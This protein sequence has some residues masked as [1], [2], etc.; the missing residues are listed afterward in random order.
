M[1]I[2]QSF[3][4]LTVAAYWIFLFFRDLFEP[5]AA[6]HMDWGWR[7]AFLCQAFFCRILPGLFLLLFRGIRSRWTGLTILAQSLWCGTF[8]I[9]KRSG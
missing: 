2:L 8:G 5:F 1:L 4:A 7:A 9:G 3:A 6:W